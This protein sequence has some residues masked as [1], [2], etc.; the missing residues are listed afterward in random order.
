MIVLGKLIMI[1]I[2]IY[3]LTIHYG[4]VGTAIAVT[5]PMVL[6]QVYLWFLINRLTGITIRTL[7]GQVIRPVLLAGIMYSLI[8]LLKTILP[9]TNIPLFFFYV[10]I[11]ILIYGAGILIFDKELINEFKS[12]KS[13]K[14]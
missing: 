5:V 9:L 2:I 6:E 12:L 3:P 14:Q 7:L 4:I 11:G 13:A 8:M 1:A 10:L